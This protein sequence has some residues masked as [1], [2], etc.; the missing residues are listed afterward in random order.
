MAATLTSIEP[1]TGATLWTGEAGDVEAEVAA[2][3]AA[4]AGWAAQPVRLPGRDAA[5]LRQRRARA[6]S[7]P[8][9]T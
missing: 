9:P 6:S 5:P 4:W 1:A 2:A 3:R 7:S 8:S